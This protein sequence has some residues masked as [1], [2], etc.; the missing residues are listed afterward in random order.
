MKR[1]W[2]K[3]G[4]VLLGVALLT[5]AGATVKPGMGQPVVN[6]PAAPTAPGVAGTPT[7]ARSSA[8]S[9]PTAEPLTTTLEDLITGL[10][11]TVRDGSLVVTAVRAGSV[12]QQAGLRVGDVIVAVGGQSDLTLNHLVTLLGGQAHKHLEFSVKRS[13]QEN[14]QVMSV[15]AP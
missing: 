7:P 5:W 8:T 10:T 2:L 13:G 9:T 1:P 6:P 12:A 14:L 3:L 11:V 4:A 15:T